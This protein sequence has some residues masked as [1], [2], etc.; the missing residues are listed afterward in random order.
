VLRRVLADAAAGTRNAIRQLRSLLIEIYP[1]ALE[2]S[3]LA[4][5]LPDLTAPL[6]AR[7]MDVDVEIEPDL[8]L[9]ADAEQLLFRAAQEALRNAGAHAAAGHVSVSVGQHN[10]SARLLVADDGRGFDPQQLADRRAEGHMG[11]S[12]I[13]DLAEAAGGRLSVTSQPGEGTRVEL[14]LPVS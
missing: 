3:G 13:R 2:D 7:G 14:E 8:R 11:L 1:P 10:G 9:P 12:I 6:T 5:A 4:A